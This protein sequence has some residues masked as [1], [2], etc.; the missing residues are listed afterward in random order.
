MDLHKHYNIYVPQLFQQ[1]FLSYIIIIICKYYFLYVKNLT[2]ITLCHFIIFCIQ[3]IWIHVCIYF[4]YYK[5][6]F[7]IMHVIIYYLFLFFVI[8]NIIFIA[9]TSRHY[10][11]HIFFEIFMI[12]IF[13]IKYYFCR[14]DMN[15]IMF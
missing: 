10:I 11:D 6:S 1:H 3:C 12:Y 8:N 4:Y 7:H 15:D 5:K 2:S 14:S 13:W 9:I